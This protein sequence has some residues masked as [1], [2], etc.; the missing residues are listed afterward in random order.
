MSIGF[1]EYELTKKEQ[2]YLEG[3]IAVLIDSIIQDIEILLAGKPWLETMMLSKYLPKNYL[4]R[5]DSTL[6]KQFLD[7]VMAVAYKFQDQEAFWTLNS[8][9]EQMAMNAILGEAEGYAENYNAKID[10]AK[11][12]DQ[13]FCDIDFELLFDPRFDGIE[14]DEEFKAAHGMENLSFKDWFKP[15]S[16]E[17]CKL[18]RKAEKE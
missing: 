9:A 1:D 10:L 15:F 3:G 11:L 8:I 18:K 7:T 2:K 6:A 12:T 17:F 13:L 5:Y 16:S 4:H 14:D